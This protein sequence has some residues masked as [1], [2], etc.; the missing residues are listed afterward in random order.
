[1]AN[2]S[3]KMTDPTEAALSAIQDALSIRDNPSEPEAANP[4]PPPPMSVPGE[5]P[6]LEPP[7]RAVRADAEGDG[8]GFDAALGAAQEP[9]ALR[10]AIDGD[11]ESTS[12]IL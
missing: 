2:N 9:I 1:M 12:Q 7:W 5:E 8:N 4:P 3:T 6:A 10:P 11:R